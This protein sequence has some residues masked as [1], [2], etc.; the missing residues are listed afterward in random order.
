MGP[1]SFHLRTHSLVEGRGRRGARLVGESCDG[2]WTYLVQQEHSG[3]TP[4]PTWGVREGFLEEVVLALSLEEE[5]ES[6]E[7]RGGN[8]Q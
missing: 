4:D 2:E 6:E 8:P 3:E 1:G 5:Q 7:A